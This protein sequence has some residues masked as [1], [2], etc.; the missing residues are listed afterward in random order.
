MYSAF[1]YSS[2]LTT[3]LT[4]PVVV[5]VPYVFILQKE[6]EKA[7][8]YE[9]KENLSEERQREYVFEWFTVVCTL[10]ILCVFHC[11]FQ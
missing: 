4:V 11:Y 5:L 1:N 9:T 6:A 10:A 7:I 3:L 2:F 8:D